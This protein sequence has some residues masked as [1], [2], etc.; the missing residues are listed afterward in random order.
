[1]TITWKEFGIKL[2]FTPNITNTGNIRLHVAPE[3]SSLDFANGLT[4]EGFNIPSILARRVETDVELRPGQTLAIGG[5]MDNQMLKDVDKIPLLGDIPILGFFF[6]SENAR[7]D[8]TELLVLVTPYLLDLDNLPYEHLPTGDAEDWE[9]D[10][11]I[12]TWID[13]RDTLSARGSNGSGGGI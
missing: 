6:R 10:G 2:D 3:V 12:R 5:L 13:G 8:R 11:H 1:M 4:Y 7:Q 9:W